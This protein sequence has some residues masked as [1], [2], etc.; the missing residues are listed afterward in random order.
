MTDKVHCT[1]D[2]THDHEHKLQKVEEFVNNSA[3]GEQGDDKLQADV[4]AT[5]SV[6]KLFDKEK[7]EEFVKNSANM[8]AEGKPKVDGRKE[9]AAAHY[10][11]TEHGK[12]GTFFMWVHGLPPKMYVGT[13]GEIDEMKNDFFKMAREAGMIRPNPRERAEMRRKK[14]KAEKRRVAG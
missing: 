7:I 10:Y 1:E 8:I 13:E 5:D 12:I 11:D 14:R 4:A 9:V 3:D 2:C 6:M